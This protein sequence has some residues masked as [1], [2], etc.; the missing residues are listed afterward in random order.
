MP[1]TTR[2]TRPTP[3]L[4]AFRLAE[5]L[6]EFRYRVEQ[7][8]AWPDDPFDPLTD[9]PDEVPSESV[10]EGIGDLLNELK[11][12]AEAVPAVVGG[13]PGL[14]RVARE[15]GGAAAA[16]LRRLVRYWF[17]RGHR[18]RV[19]D[20]RRQQ[21][22]AL[23]G[24][25]R[26]RLT[27]RMLEGSPVGP[28]NWGR[29]ELAART[30]EVG[31]PG[32]YQPLFALGRLLGRVVFPAAEDYAAAG[33]D[34]WWDRPR[35]MILPAVRATLTWAAEG[36]PRLGGLR[37]ADAGNVSQELNR[38]RSAIRKELGGT[39]DVGL[40]A[41]AAGAVGPAEYARLAGIKAELTM[42][43]AGGTAGVCEYVGDSVPILKVFEQIA[44][45]RGSGSRAVLL[46]GPKGIGKTTLAEVIHRALAGDHRGT[47]GA[48]PPAAREPRGRLFRWQASNSQA[49]DAL[50]PRSQ[51]LGF[52]A[53][54]GYQNVPAG[55]KDGLLK[56]CSGGSIFVDE[57]GDLHPD[58]QTLL[59][60][61]AEGREVIPICGGRK[62][63]Y[64]PNVRLI[65]ATNKD[66]RAVIRDDLLDRIGMR[67]RIP[68]L[69]DRP[70]DL[71][72]LVRHHL[73]GTGFVLS[74]RTWGLFVA[75][76][77]PGNIRELE[78]TLKLV[79]AAHRLK[80][81]PPPKRKPRPTGKAPKT[82]ELPHAL[83]LQ[84][85]EGLRETAARVGDAPAADAAEYRL[86]NLLKGV[87]EGQGFRASARRPDARPLY[88]RMGELLGMHK[89]K[90]A[91]LKRGAEEY[92]AGTMPPD[93]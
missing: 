40:A 35:R 81:K 47:G 6:A 21:R 53:N 8:Y 20:R 67:I 61:V 72:P 5:T 50:G 70:E 93:E 39:P 90:V 51:W 84:E 45:G 52:A 66:V 25:D 59:L 38:L 62:D 34:E 58:L 10:P 12:S 65:L 71:F 16:V 26:V 56:E 17:K 43:A 55:G 13:R 87:L 15:V 19:R 75:H 32:G 86:F 54:S 7:L 23:G 4:A 82:Q 60:D 74:P 29:Y 73:T 24:A 63:A 57:F 77:W 9:D 33:G 28:D 41:P 27:L 64:T 36:V 2:R 91:R 48:G 46:L 42:P 80:S 79:Q 78:Q 31:L 89:S 44:V 30:F 37:V 11:R 14:D 1:A 88:A 49:T 22:D 18:G 69:R 83:F 68:P 85:S 3:P 76:A 92:E